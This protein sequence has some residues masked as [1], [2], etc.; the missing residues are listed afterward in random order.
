MTRSMRMT[1]A[2]AISLTVGTIPS[3]VGTQPSSLERVV[4]LSDAIV[5]GR[6]VASDT[7]GTNVGGNIVTRHSFAVDAW[8]YGSGPGTISLLTEGGFHTVLEGERERRLWTTVHGAPGVTV[9]EELLI[10]LK[11]VDRTA[12]RDA[13]V[14]RRGPFYR[15]VVWDGAKFRIAASAETGERFVVLRVQSKKYLRSTVALESFARL[16]QLPEHKD[17][18]S[19]GRLPEG[20]FAAERIPVTD[21]T[22][23]LGEIIR[24]LKQ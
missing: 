7:D 16:E 15:F 23:R 4:G 24:D 11:S 3:A 21:L 22:E 1:C 2:V 13:D 18:K 12:V 5:P 8:Y 19:T 9:G 6:V 20:N 14:Q 10:F 17:L